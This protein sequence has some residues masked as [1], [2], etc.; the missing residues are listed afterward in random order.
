MD[1]YKVEAMQ[2]SSS[3]DCG[4]ATKIKGKWSPIYAQAMMVELENGMRF[5]TNFR[6][7]LK[8]DI[9]PNPTTEVR[10]DKLE[11]IQALGPDSTEAFQS[12]CDATMVGHVMV[13]DSNDSMK[14]HRAQ[15]FYGRQVMKFNVE[16]DKFVDKGASLEANNIVTHN[17][18]A[19]MGLFEAIGLQQK[20][21]KKETKKT[22]KALVDLSKKKHDHH[23]R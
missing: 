18:K 4:K 14:A 17:H 10:D 7:N 2:C 1:E 21:D 13:K 16:E 3:N 8:P 6:Y 19:S 23:P 9:S 11:F 15:C 20:D 22:S 5:V 12:Q